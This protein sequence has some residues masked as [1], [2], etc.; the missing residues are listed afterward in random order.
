MEDRSSKR[1]RNENGNHKRSY[2]HDFVSYQQFEIPETL[3]ED[4]DA[5]HQNEVFLMNY[6]CFHYFSIEL[7][8]Y[9]INS[10]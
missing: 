2:I 1:Y 9:F 3:Y 5:E 8:V 7:K 6:L 4:S 10:G